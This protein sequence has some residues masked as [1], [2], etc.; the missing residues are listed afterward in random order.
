MLLA[1]ATLFSVLC[2]TPEVVEFGAETPEILATLFAEAVEAED[3]NL[4]A[5]LV[6]PLYGLEIGGGVDFSGFHLEID[7]IRSLGN[8]DYYACFAPGAT[9]VTI[10]VGQLGWFLFSGWPEDWQL[11]DD[12]IPADEESSEKID[13]VK[14]YD[15]SEY[16]VGTA[17]LAPFANAGEA[18]MVT[19]M[20]SRTVRDKICSGNHSDVDLIIPGI[21]AEY[22]LIRPQPWLEEMGY[23]ESQLEY[24]LLMNNRV[25]W[26]I[27][28]AVFVHLDNRWYLRFAGEG[29][30]Q[31]F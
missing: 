1:A 12:L 31:P 15:L 17:F 20:I 24:A 29:I 10:F 23:T 4:L 22:V 6:H 19:A 13:M 2:M 14:D 28:Y 27:P 9:D 30:P 3:E 21:A 11:P 18:E 26:S 8:G 7:E 5:D 16:T 25:E